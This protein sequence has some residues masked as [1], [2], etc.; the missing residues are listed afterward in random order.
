VAKG[1]KPRSVLSAASTP[2]RGALIAFMAATSQAQAEAT[3]L[4]NSTEP[5]WT[6]GMPVDHHT[7]PPSP[8]WAGRDG[9]GRS[10]GQGW[11]RASEGRRIVARRLAQC[12][13]GASRAPTGP[14]GRQLTDTMGEHRSLWPLRPLGRVGM[15][16][17]DRAARVAKDS[18]G[19][20]GPAAAARLTA[21]ACHPEYQNVGR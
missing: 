20:R 10:G 6:A 4:T 2:V 9:E 7:P 16:R 19:R 5:S 18:Q 21:P 8:P 11:R 17:V 15:A 14:L 1:S 12:T 13:R 3:S